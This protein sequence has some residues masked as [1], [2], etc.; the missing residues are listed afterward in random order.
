MP[1]RQAN[2]GAPSSVTTTIA[3]MAGQSSK[4]GLATPD[5][6]IQHSVAVRIAAAVLPGMPS[7]LR[8]TRRMAMRPKPRGSGICATQ[9]GR[10]CTSTVAASRSTDVKSQAASAMSAVTEPATTPVANRAA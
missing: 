6:T 2:T 9:V 10:P 1:P 7:P 5:R 4:S 8:I 3:A